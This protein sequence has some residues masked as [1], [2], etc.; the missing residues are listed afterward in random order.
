MQYA[1]AV[2]TINYINAT[3][4][5]Y[6][7]ISSVMAAFTI[8]SCQGSIAKV[9]KSLNIL[10]NIVRYYISRYYSISVLV[11]AGVHDTTS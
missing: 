5:F 2:R 3:N 9:L 10:P 1:F 7:T 6:Y 8:H 11:L 4:D